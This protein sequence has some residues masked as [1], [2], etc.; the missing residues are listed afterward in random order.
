LGRSYLFPGQD[1]EHLSPYQRQLERLYDQIDRPGNRITPQQFFKSPEFGQFVTQTFGGIPVPPGANLISQ[2]PFEVVYRDAEGYEHKLTRDVSGGKEGGQVTEQTSRPAVLPNQQ[3]QT[4]VN[5]LQNSVIQ[6]LTS[7]PTL[8]Q[9]P[10]DVAAQ[11]QAISDAEVARNQQAGQQ[12]QS[13]ILAQ[14][15]GNRVNQSSIATGAGAQF[16]QQQGLVNQQQ[17][18]D[19]AGRNL[20]IR[21]LLTQLGQ[22]NAQVGAGLLGELSGQQNTRDIA[23]A[24]FGLDAKK[25]EETIRQFNASNTLEGLKVQNQQEQLDAANSPFSKFIQTLNA[26]AG[27]AG[28]VGTG[29]SAYGALAGGKK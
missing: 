3:Q 26:A 25:L 2:T 4:A 29:I 23:N 11:L 12:T 27:L 24:G 8:Q 16:A 28:G 22:Q 21:Q 6:G 19:A 14:L 9:L 7:A 5:T 10:P 18:S 17:Q 13:Q 20:A 1:V 15:F